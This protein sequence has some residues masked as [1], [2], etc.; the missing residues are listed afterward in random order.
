MTS[1]THLQ[2]L[3]LNTFNGYSSESSS[4]SPPSS[5]RRPGKVPHHRRR[6]RVKDHLRVRPGNFFGRVLSRR[7]LRIF[8]LLPLLYISYLL[9]LL[10]I[11]LLHFCT[12]PPPTISIS[13]PTSPPPLPQPGSVY[14]SHEVF[15]NLWPD[16][17]SDNVSGIELSSLWRY[18]K[19]QKEGKPCKNTSPGRRHSGSSVPSGYLIVEAN[20]GLNQ[21]RTSIC[22]AVAVAGL[23]DAV[24]V[25]PQFDFHSVW[26]DPSG[27]SDIYDENH[28]ITTLKGYVK[29]VQQLPEVLMERYHYNISKI[30]SFKV[31][32]WAEASYYMEEVYPILRKKGVIRIAPFANRLAMEVPHNIQFL[33]CLA[34][35]KAL[36]FSASISRFAKKLVNRMIKKSSGTG[37]RF[38]SVHLRFEE[39]MVAFSCCIY[40]GGES[41]KLKMDKIREKGWRGKF[42]REGREDRPDLNR[43]DGKCPLT[44]LEVGMMLRGMGF[45]NNTAI[46]LASGKI[47]EAERNL[48]PLKK[49]F[50]LLQTKESLATPEELASF[51]GYSSRLAALDYTVCLFSE[52]FVTTQGGNF[53]HHLM[54]HRRF[55]Y[56]HA[57]TIR[58]DKRKLVVLLHNT[59]ISWKDFKVHVEEML[60]ESDRKGIMVPRMGQES[61]QTSIY[62]YPFPECRCLHGS[63]NLTLSSAQTLH[64][65]GHKP[66]AMV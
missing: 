36:R 16:I 12:P 58:P 65:I 4:C 14:R 38:V 18:R 19:R 17:Q 33:R 63:Q 55:L 2:N 44:P 9:I 54:G 37:G 22:N 53:P 46:Y 28:F 27:F 42:T 47:Y 31:K 26:K 57:K 10:G 39:D 51:E 24:L 13:A 49:M 20:G 50:P 8:I 61:K 35:Y 52:I 29:I 34:N 56:G 30:R 11:A 1:K 59:S 7:N 5:P 40:D 64:S 48:T 66:H 25:I 21:Q 23:L 3:A 43:I 60:V 62:A 32:A 41:E 15:Q 6:Y 45:D